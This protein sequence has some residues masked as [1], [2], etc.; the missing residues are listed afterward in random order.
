MA[1]SEL[2]TL[3]NLDLIH[4]LGSPPHSRWNQKHVTIP[5]DLVSGVDSPM[6]RF[7]SNN[8]A[9]D[10]VEISTRPFS[11]SGGSDQQYGKISSLVR[12]RRGSSKAGQSCGRSQ[13]HGLV[14]LIR[15]GTAYCVVWFPAA[16]SQ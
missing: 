4:L 13:G 14:C 7:N 10:V 1:C 16:D 2:I 12:F 6:A 5:S 9:A 3:A 15:L 8:A 11:L